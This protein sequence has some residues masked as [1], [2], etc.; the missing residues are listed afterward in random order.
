MMTKKQQLLSEECPLQKPKLE[1]NTK[2]VGGG[3]MISETLNTASTSRRPL[4]IFLE[5][6]HKSPSASLPFHLYESPQASLS[7]VHSFVALKIRLMRL[8]NACTCQ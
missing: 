8:Q 1:A 6:H 3:Q 2:R 7:R 4:R 5:T